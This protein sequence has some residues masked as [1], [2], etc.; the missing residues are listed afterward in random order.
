VVIGW[1]YQEGAYRGYD[2]ADVRKEDV[3][4][5]YTGEWE[6]HKLEW[7][8]HAEFLKKYDVRYVYVGPVEREEY[9]N[10][11]LDFSQYPGVE[12]VFEN[13]GVVIY[14]VDYSEID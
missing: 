3:D 9:P 10:A 8:E 7:S 12:P 2:K 4:V 14:R 13:D 6:G 1:V 11:D 5:I